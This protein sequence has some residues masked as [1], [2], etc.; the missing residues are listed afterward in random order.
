MLRPGDDE[1]EPC[2]RRAYAGFHVDPPET[3]ARETHDAA[4]GRPSPCALGLFHRD[5]RGECRELH[6]QKALVG[7]RG[8]TYHYQK[9]AFAHSCTSRT[10]PPA[11]PPRFFRLDLSPLRV[12]RELNETLKARSARVLKQT[13]VTTRDDEM[14]SRHASRHD[15]SCDFN[16]ALINL[17]DAS[18][19]AS[20]SDVPLKDESRYGMGPTSVS[21]HSDSSLQP[22]STVAVPR[23]LHER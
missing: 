1:Y 13:R 10:F 14:M 8:M 9:S 12:V 11:D 17:M 21:W 4:V 5:A 6:V 7:E 20:R 15:G 23:V 18:A 19:A 3:L 22:F 16:V 2:V